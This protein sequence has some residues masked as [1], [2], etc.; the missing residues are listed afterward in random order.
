MRR[1]RYRTQ[2]RTR[3]LSLA[4]NEPIRVALFALSKNEIIVA[5]IRGRDFSLREF[6]KSRD[7][8]IP[9]IA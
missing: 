2:Y 8:P 4:C 3:D 6:R 9:G 7:I 1:T 5:Y